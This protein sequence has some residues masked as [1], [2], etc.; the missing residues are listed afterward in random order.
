LQIAAG[1]KAQGINVPPPTKIA[2]FCLKAVKVA[3][4]PQ[5]ALPN[6]LPKELLRKYLRSENLYA[7][8]GAHDC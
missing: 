2:I 5:I 3:V 6:K 7:C 8:N 4:P 1:I